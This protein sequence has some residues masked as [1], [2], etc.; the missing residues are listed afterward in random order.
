[1]KTFTMAIASVAGLC[2]FANLQSAS[3]VQQAG[4]QSGP[5]AVQDARAQHGV[6]TGEVKLV[7][8]VKD[9]RK[10]VEFYRGVLG[11]EFHSFH[12][13]A[14]GK[15]VTEW[16]RA[17]PPIYAEISA[18]RQKVGLHAPQTA[19]DESCV[20][21]GRF[22]FRVKDVDAHR[23]RVV[24]RGA[25]PGPIRDTDWMRMFSVTDPG[26]YKITFATT[27]EGVHKID[28]W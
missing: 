15:S 12:D 18:G 13:Y 5:G 19:Y 28:P 17:E 2:W 20:G 1:M 11:F 26:G 14:S 23:R 22:Y 24:A 8:H 6:F 9:V 27:Q 4:P 10:S 16:N 7:L 3:T 21:R 25:E